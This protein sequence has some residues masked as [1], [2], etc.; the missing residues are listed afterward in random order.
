MIGGRRSLRVR[1]TAWFTAALTTALVAYAVVV[2]LSLRR[3]LW[4]ELDDRLHHE[5]ETSEGLLQPYWSAAGLWTPGG[6]SPLDDD[7]HRW[8]Q[9]WSPDGRLLFESETAKQLPMPHLPPATSDVARSLTIPSSGPYRVKD[10]AGHIARQPVVVR[11]ALSEARV[12]DELSEMLF[13]MGATLPLCALASAYGGYRLVRRTLSPIDR[14]VQA[15]ASITADNLTSRLPLESHDEVGRIA[16]A[17]NQTL[18]RLEASFTQMRRFSAN[19]S[20]E[21][22]TPLAAIRS[23]GQLA[24]SH[25]GAEHEHRDA[26]ASM[27]EEAEHL[28]KLL[29]T[30]LVLARSD[31]G[32]IQLQREPLDILALVYGVA[33]ECRVL[34]DEKNQTLT[35]DGDEAWLEADPTVLRIAVANVVHNAIRYSTSGTRVSVRVV[36]HAGS[37]TIDVAD[38]GPGIPPEHL[39]LI[40]ERF[41]RVDSGRSTYAG[42]AGLGLAMA[43]WAVVAHGGTITAHNNVVGSTFSITLPHLRS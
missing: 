9:V 1:V 3:V 31:A 21:L 11:V 25:P 34:A 36:A 32:Q 14:L 12:R 8:L 20:H 23:T 30:L 43:R 29:D 5:I 22:R 13:L 41:H 16:A 10:E 24:L 39:E 6:V 19:A 7:D 27:V 26:I 40:F 2:Y 28:G 15:T 37:V 38:T 17:F 4:A 33:S 18:A 42:G 35:L